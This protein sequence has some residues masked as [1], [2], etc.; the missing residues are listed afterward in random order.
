MSSGNY[1][2]KAGSRNIGENQR[3]L[4]ADG[5]WKKSFLNCQ[6]SGWSYASEQS[7][8][9]DAR[10]LENVVFSRSSRRRYLRLRRSTHT[11]RISRSYFSP[12]AVTDPET[13]F[14]P[15]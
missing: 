14:R 11:G 3:K 9:R 8:F 4:K 15:N 1:R 12:R 6:E 2:F 10:R 13:H 5:I 7:E